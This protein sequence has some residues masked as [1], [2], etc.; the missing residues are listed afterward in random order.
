MLQCLSWKCLS[1]SHAHLIVLC[2][3]LNISAGYS[4]V[5]I[6]SFKNTV[7]QDQRLLTSCSV[8]ERV[9]LWDHYAGPIDQDAIKV[10]F[11]R[12]AH[13]K[14]PPFRF[15]VKLPPRNRVR[16]SIFLWGRELH[17]ARWWFMKSLLF[18]QTRPVKSWKH[19]CFTIN[20]VKYEYSI[21]ETW[22]LCLW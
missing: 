5:I 10:E 16:V 13:R 2:S 8:T 17:R 12:K 19:I 18:H 1:E 15:K 7:L 22:G 4:W 6:G 3:R 20:E 11:F 9:R 14:N 21:R